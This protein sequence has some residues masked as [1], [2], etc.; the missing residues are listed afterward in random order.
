MTNSNITVWNFL[1]LVFWFCHPD[2]LLVY[3][4]QFVETP[5]SKNQLR[6]ENKCFT[7]GSCTHD[8]SPIQDALNPGVSLVP[9]PQKNQRQSIQKRTLMM[10]VGNMLTKYFLR[11]SKAFGQNEGVDMIVSPSNFNVN[12]CTKLSHRSSSKCWCYGKATQ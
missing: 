5:S 4:D 2:V 7:V 10:I 1:S 9:F 6:M 12:I 11:P 8:T 3:L